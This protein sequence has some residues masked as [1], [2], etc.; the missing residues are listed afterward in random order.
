MTAALETLAA[1]GVRHGPR[2]QSQRE[3]E[4]VERLVEKHGENYGAMFRDAV[5]NPMQQSE[6]DIRRRVVLWRRNKFPATS[7]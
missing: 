2:K 7:D 5:L 3:Q 1:G 6:G 4:W